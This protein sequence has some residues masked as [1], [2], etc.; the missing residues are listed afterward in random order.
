MDSKNFAFGL[1]GLVQ[2]TRC[3]CLFCLVW[4][5][6]WKGLLHCCYPQM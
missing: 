1:V 2:N 5:S 3:V 4:V 6:G